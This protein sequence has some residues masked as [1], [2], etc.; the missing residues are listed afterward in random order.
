MKFMFA[1]AAVLVNCLTVAAQSPQ[2]PQIIARSDLA[3]A[4]TRF[5]QVYEAH[6]PGDADRGRVHRGVD[7]AVML[8][9]TAKHA[10]AMQTL[11]QIT[12][13]LPGGNR[14]AHEALIHSLQVRI[15]PAI[16]RSGRPSVM[17]VRIAR[18][19]SVPMDGP[20]ELH[21]I[22]RTDDAQPQ[23]ILDEPVKLEP[24]GPPFSLT[25]AQPKAANGRYIVEL[26]T[27]D[28]TKYPV[29]D[30]VVTESP[31]DSLR[32]TNERLLNAVVAQTPQVSQALVACR[33]R[34]MLLTDRRDET[35]PASYLVDPIELMRS[36]KGEVGLL[37][38][39]QDPYANLPGDLWRAILSGGMEIPARTYAP[40]Q[41]N[42]KQPMPL[43][44][45]LHDLGG[46]ENT[47]MQFVGNGRLKKLAEQHGF[48]LVTP[49][50]NWVTRNPAIA[51]DSV[52][53]AMSAIYPVD[54][55]KVYVLA[56][57]TGAM[58]ACQLS[59]GDSS[60]V[61]KMVLFSGA[62]LAGVKRLPPTLLYVGELD[63]LFTSQLAESTMDLARRAKLPVELRV[64]KDSGHYLVVHD[65]LA[66]A[67][68][69]LA[70]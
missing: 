22:I 31:L 19:Y 29:D 61:A 63:P 34:N 54:S 46:D 69:W 8:Y 43:L 6:P 16:A 7:Q 70:K 60:K 68:E 30:W 25:R 9:F 33:S 20:L 59:G 50:V 12:D 10:E 40:Q 24:E 67:V 18:M 56:Q 32:I 27:A 5:E 13:S 41:I 1:T 26:V 45:A 35:S 23:T 66:E 14:P 17:R 48:L 44:I 3:S 11:N 38:Q 37:M 62:D 47:F 2:L 64:R 53:D 52:V 39:G 28:G 36:V 65:N 57:G 42:N 49:N 58:A 15:S 4:Q 21:L 55:S 51:V